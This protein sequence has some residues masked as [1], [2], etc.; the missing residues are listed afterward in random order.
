MKYKPQQY[1]DALFDLIKDA[2]AEKR[3]TLIKRFG[4]ILEKNK[5]QAKLNVILRQLE[6]RVIKDAGQIKVVLESADPL[7]K[8]A[9]D[10]IESALGKKAYM[11]EKIKPELLAGVRMLVDDSIFID[12]TAKRH[13]DNLFSKK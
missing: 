6:R 7:S 3:K 2:S 1:A 4:S 13:L 5:D 12:A 11:I 10:D 8:K 9:K